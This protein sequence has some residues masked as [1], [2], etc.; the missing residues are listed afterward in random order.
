MKVTTKSV[1]KALKKTKEAIGTLTIGTL[2]VIE[3]AIETD[4]DE[5]RT[6]GECWEKYGKYGK[7][8]KRKLYYFRKIRISS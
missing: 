8:D 3:T 1:K 2:T 7:I 5:I 6:V 4:E